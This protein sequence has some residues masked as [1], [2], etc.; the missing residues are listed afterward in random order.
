MGYTPEETQK[1][2][3]TFY[4]DEKKLRKGDPGRPEQCPVYLLHRIYTQKAKET[5]APPCKTGELGC[6]DCKKRLTENLNKAME[7]IREKRN[8]LLKQ[9]DHI[10]DVLKEGGNQARERARSVM[11]KVRTAMKMNYRK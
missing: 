9:P 2:I 10:W 7:P 11:D 1:R 4:T 3:K 8:E 5:I 6:A